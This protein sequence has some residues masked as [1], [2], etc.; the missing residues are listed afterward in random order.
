MNFITQYSGNDTIGDPNGKLYLF[1]DLGNIHDVLPMIDNVNTY[2]RF[3]VIGFADHHFNGYGVNPVSTKATVIRSGDTRNAA[4]VSIIWTAAQ[5]CSA[6]N[7]EIH[8]VT[9]DKGFLELQNL[10]LSS[11]S[12]LRFHNSSNMFF[13]YCKTLLVCV[14]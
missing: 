3:H 6:Y 9:K 11:G 2:D 10:V 13:N 5:I 1:V 4:D 14:P 7:C 8:I 12:S